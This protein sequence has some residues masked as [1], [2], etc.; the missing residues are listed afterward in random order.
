M[1]LSSGEW[2]QS[3]LASALHC[4]SYSA[5]VFGAVASNTAR[6]DFTAIADKIFQNVRALVVDH[7]NL[8]GAKAA[9]FAVRASSLLISKFWFPFSWAL[10]G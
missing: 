2:Q 1:I 6:Y 10:T 4:Y 3:N 9:H 7:L 5:L 8:F